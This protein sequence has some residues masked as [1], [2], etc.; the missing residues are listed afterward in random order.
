MG[1]KSYRLYSKNEISPMGNGGLKTNAEDTA[2]PSVES[3]R[4][5]LEET[6]TNFE[7]DAVENNF[8]FSSII[9]FDDCSGSL[10]HLPVSVVVNN[11]DKRFAFNDN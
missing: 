6:N 7:S 3:S 11:I 5:M 1:K 8:S 10:I 4:V 2:R 9:D